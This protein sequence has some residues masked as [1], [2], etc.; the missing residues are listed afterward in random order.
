VLSSE[1]FIEMKTREKAMPYN[2]ANSGA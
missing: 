1:S 2:P